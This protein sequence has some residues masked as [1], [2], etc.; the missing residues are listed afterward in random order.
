[1]KVRLLAAVLMVVALVGTGVEAAR[2]PGKVKKI[3]NPPKKVQSYSELASLLRKYQPRYGVTPR[4]MN[5][6]MVALAMADAAPA[7]TPGGGAANHSETNVQVAGVD[8]ADFVKTDGAYIY[9]VSGST[10]YI[11]KAV[12]GQPMAVVATVKFDSNFTPQELYIDGNSL[13]LIGSGWERLVN[14]VPEEGPVGV[15]TMARLW[16]FASQ[17]YMK[18]IVYDISDKANP[19]A[20]RTIRVDGDYLTS[21]KVDQNV[22][23]VARK[24]PNY[25]FGYTVVN[26]AKAKTPPPE[27]LVPAFS[28]TAIG[29]AMKPMAPNRIMYFPGFTDP[30]YVVIA[31]FSLAR[32]T[33]A[34]DTQAYLGAG[35][36]VYASRQNL[37]VSAAATN[38][39]IIRPMLMI[40]AGAE[41]VPS[42]ASVEST[43]LYKF[44]LREGA[45]ELLGSGDVPG[46]VLNQFSMDEDGDNFRV[47]TTFH[48]WWSAGDQD[49]NNV[50]V[51]DRDLGI[52]G[53][54]EGIAPGERIYSTRFM[55]SR[56]YLVTF[57]NIDPLF[58][59][60]LSQPTQPTILG[61]LKIPG[62]SNYLHP[63]DATHVLGFG[64]DAVVIDGA[65]NGDAA[66]WNGIAFYQ[67]MKVALFDVSDV[68]NPVVMHSVIIGDRGTDSDLLWDH[69]ALLFDRARNLLAFPI[70]VCQ[71]ADPAAL[72]QPWEYGEAVFQGA[73]VY[74]LTL[75][76]GFEF[77]GGITHTNAGDDLW[78][79]W[80]HAIHRIMYID[81]SLYTVSDSR[82][83][84][85]DMDTLEEQ[86]ILDLAPPAAIVGLV[87]V[88]VDAAGVSKTGAG[89]LVLSGAQ[90]SLGV[91][92]SGVTPVPTGSTV[93]S[94]GGSTLA[95][96]GTLVLNGSINLAGAAG[97]IALSNTCT[98]AVTLTGG[99]VVDLSPPAISALGSNVS[100]L[101]LVSLG[102]GL[103]STRDLTLG[104]G[105][106]LV[107]SGGTTLSAATGIVIW[108][109]H[110]QVD[111]GG[112]TLSAP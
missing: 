57:Q 51:L 92:D 5:G 16:W 78:S 62:Y 17:N 11:V 40:R 42:R 36:T 107:L 32:P 1:M 37:Y 86:D 98:G 39:M 2:Y 25:Y 50:Y 111:A 54:L 27:Q 9:Q 96:G 49:S 80:Q 103:G 77:K 23:L 73:Y 29:G 24:Y 89:T 28:D 95:I 71:F 7:A 45:V 100:C 52:V 75:E 13:V 15:L 30:N 19:Q 31:S 38:H 105:G 99:G 58:V 64:K 43:R 4:M 18:A 76:N 46:S 12:P 14:N 97:T 44:A 85:N 106:T 8:E 84:A 90:V 6:G 68:A 21:R 83:L 26:K 22:Y 104:M 41:R 48:R 66:W 94:S 112:V 33:Q 70:R 79:A 10:L 93:V 72:R 67:G 35:D 60:D 53:R 69:K 110:L 108:P 20:V 91:L 102:S 65:A 88:P 47:A 34:V 101:S 81:Q 74:N 61:E 56:L 109:G 87:P 59:I 63:Y 82:I 55:G 3:A